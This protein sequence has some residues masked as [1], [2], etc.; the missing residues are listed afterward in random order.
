MTAPLTR[1][2]RRGLSLIE[3]ILAIAIGAIAVVAVVGFY[4]SGTAANNRN[5]A[6]QQLQHIVAEMQTLYSSSATY[7]DGTANDITGPA[8]T[9]GIFPAGM[10][11]V[12][13]ASAPEV[14]NPWGG[15]VTVDEGDVAQTFTVTYN[16]VPND[17]C[18]KM[19]AGNSSGFGGNLCGIGVGDGS[20]PSGPVS[21]NGGTD[22]CQGSR[23]SISE[24]DAISACS[25]TDSQNVI[26]WWF[27]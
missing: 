22:N 19:I 4:T 5:E 13:S 3:T 10:V 6:Q 24:T 8:S 17:A 16:N 11:A 25:S 12:A 7:G 23:P 15:E 9:A 18:A 14:Y 21:T 20:A 2:R 1:N 27:Q 26:T